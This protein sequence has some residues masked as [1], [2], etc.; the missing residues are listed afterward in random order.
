M[1]DVR[2]LLLAV[3]SQVLKPFE[4]AGDL[5]VEKG[6]LLYG[7]ALGGEDVDSGGVFFKGRV[8]TSSVEPLYGVEDSLEEFLFGGFFDE[9]FV[10]SVGLQAI[11]VVVAHGLE[12][13]FRLLQV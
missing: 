2:Q 10:V 7:L 12:L 3:H 13:V 1:G 6:A 9:A 11:S 8:F 4:A 5:V